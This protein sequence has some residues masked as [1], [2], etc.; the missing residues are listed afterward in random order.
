MLGGVSS[1]PELP[2]GAYPGGLAMAKVMQ[3]DMRP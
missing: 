1:S 2:D 3:K